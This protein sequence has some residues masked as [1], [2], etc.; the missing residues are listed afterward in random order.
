M[1]CCGED[2]SNRCPGSQLSQQFKKNVLLR[3]TRNSPWHQGA[4][5]K[6]HG[7]WEP[8]LHGAGCWSVQLLLGRLEAW[9]PRAHKKRKGHKEKAQRPTEGWRTY[10]HRKRTHCVQRKFNNFP[11]SLDCGNSAFPGNNYAIFSIFII[12]FVTGCLRGLSTISFKQHLTTNT[13]PHVI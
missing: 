5:S 2:F 3:Q 1:G 6:V 10:M 7:V 13:S 9:L 12:Q 4:N 8:A 11:I